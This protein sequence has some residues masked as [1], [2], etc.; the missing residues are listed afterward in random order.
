M[1]GMLLVLF[2]LPLIYVLVPARA[3]RTEG[4]LAGVGVDRGAAFRGAM[5]KVHDVDMRNYY[6]TSFFDERVLA[7]WGIRICAALAFAMVVISWI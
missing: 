4:Y 1:V 6:L 2:L 3:A 5:G 7:P